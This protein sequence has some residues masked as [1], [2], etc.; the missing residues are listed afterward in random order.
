M[1]NAMHSD[2][3]KPIEYLSMQE[4]VE[5]PP[6]LRGCT[7]SCFYTCYI[8]CYTFYI[9]L[10]TVYIGCYTVYI[11]LYTCYVGCYTVSIS[12]YT[13]DKLLMYNTIRNVTPFIHF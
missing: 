8:G 10:Y 11:G 7:F 2:Y 13:C 9:G 6:S 5:R 12:C 3:K 4:H 1:R